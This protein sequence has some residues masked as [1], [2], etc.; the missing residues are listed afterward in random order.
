MDSASEDMPYK[1]G[2]LTAFEVKN[3]YWQ[4]GLNRKFGG[5]EPSALDSNVRAALE[6]WVRCLLGDYFIP[7]EDAILPVTTLIVGGTP[8]HRV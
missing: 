2:S 1:V 3:S 5:L 7:G 6:E 8:K 4:R